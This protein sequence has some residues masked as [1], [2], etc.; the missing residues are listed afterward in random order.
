VIEI[1]DQPLAERILRAAVE[2]PNPPQQLLFFGPPGTG[3]RRAARAV[4]WALIDP[5]TPHD[6]DH[7]SLDLTVVAATGASIRLEADLEPALTDLAARPVVGKRR[8]LII[9][10]AERLREQEGA[11]RILKQLEEPAPRSHVILVTDRLADLLPTIRSRCLP[12]PFRSPGWR[13]VAARL[14][15]AGLGEAQAAGLARADGPLAI[16]SG[17]FERSM[18]LIGVELAEHALQGQVSAPQLVRDIQARME[19]T[20][21]NHPSQ[22]LTDLRDEAAALAGKR[23]ERT[24][25]KRVDDQ[26][27]RERR[28]ALTDGWSHVLDGAAGLVADALAVAVGAEAAVRHQ[29]RI[30]TLRTVGV[31]SRVGFLAR[32]LDEIQLTRAEMELNPTLDLA[33]EGLLARIAAAR[34]GESHELVG[35]GRLPW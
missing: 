21:A 17:D 9:D 35:H 3:K 25:L 15:D 32:A 7:E 12:V 34:R 11:P 10:G 31:P 18:R 13:Q 26:E 29:D 14:V 16:S 2:R 4:A 1:P 20:A 30:E 33:V 5:D 22:S 27:R 24:A 19:G 6:P 23:G 28:R 8:V